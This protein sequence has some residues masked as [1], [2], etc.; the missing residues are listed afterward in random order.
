MA[1]RVLLAV[2][3]VDSQRRQL[4]G[5]EQHVATAVTDPAHHLRPPAI[6]SRLSHPCSIAA[7]S[8]IVAALVY[9][10]ARTRTDRAAADAS[11]HQRRTPRIGISGQKQ[12]LVVALLSGLAV[13]AALLY[14]R[15]RGSTVQHLLA[16]VAIP[17]FLA[18]RGNRRKRGVLLATAAS[19][20]P[21]TAAIE[22][23]G[24]N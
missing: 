23:T 10:T 15:Q 20:L 22:I 6:T 13:A 16:A 9:C 21:V 3:L 5:A 17:A 1:W 4:Q 24:K 11:S 8:A 18:T 12:P 19:T 14:L 7:V 2:K